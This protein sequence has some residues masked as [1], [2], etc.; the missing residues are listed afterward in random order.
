[1]H[2]VVLPEV[3]A[4]LYFSLFL[5]SFCN[6]KTCFFFLVLIINKFLLSFSP[7]RRISF[8]SSSSTCGYNNPRLLTSAYSR[9]LLSLVS[10]SCD[11][12][13]VSVSLPSSLAPSSAILPRAFLFSLSAARYMHSHSFSP[14]THRPSFL[15][16]LLRSFPSSLSRDS[17]SSSS[18]FF[19]RRFFSLASS[20][21][22]PTSFS[23]SLFSISRISLIFRFAFR[24]PSRSCF[25]SRRL[26]A[27]FLSPAVVPPSLHVSS[28][29]SLATRSPSA[30]SSLLAPLNYDRLAPFIS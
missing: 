17:S 10:V 21:R 7:S 15:L 3:F 2:F 20:L 5:L 1:M 14:R 6:Y 23:L 13:S 4:F 22:P 26:R 29:A 8:L 18:L 9:L 28:S 24:P 25:R 27:L 19:L 12:L 11:F 16:F 30:L